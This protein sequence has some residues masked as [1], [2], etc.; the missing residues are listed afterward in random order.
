MWFDH[1]VRLRATGGFQERYKMTEATFDVL[2]DRL[3]LPVNEI[4]SRNSTKGV[5]PIVKPMVVAIGLR[6]LGGEPHKAMED[7]FHISKSSSKRCVKRFIQAVIDDID[8][9]HLPRAE[10]LPELAVSW[11]EMST[12]PDNHLHGCVLALDGFLSVR[13][14]PDVENDAQ[15]FSTHKK[16]HCLN[17][18]AAVDNLL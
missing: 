16:F 10:E 9:I 11:S 2:V 5:D 8:N 14:T 4:K 6:F 18:Q 7:I 17:V 3:H 1:L 12:C 13:T 15:Y